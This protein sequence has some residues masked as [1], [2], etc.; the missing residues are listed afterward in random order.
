MLCLQR[1]NLFSPLRSLASPVYCVAACLC[2]WP[3]FP[4]SAQDAAVF[5]VANNGVDNSSCGSV[6]HPCRSI[7]R[8]IA[9]ASDGEL[10]EVGPGIYGDIDGDGDVSSV[11]EEARVLDVLV[12]VDKAVTIYSQAGNAATTIRGPRPPA[13]DLAL[14]VVVSVIGDG[15][16]FG[17]RGGGFTIE[18]FAPS[19]R[20]GSLGIFVDAA[21]ASVIGNITMNNGR[22]GMSLRVDRGN[23]LVQDNVA[24]RN[25]T[26][27]IIITPLPASVGRAQLDGNIA[28]DNRVVGFLTFGLGGHILNNNLATRN[29]AGF[30]FNGGPGV[31]QNNAA[32]ANRGVGI[33]VSSPTGA[34]TL[35]A[36]NSAIGNGVAGFRF[37]G[38][39]F[40]HRVQ[41]N[42]IFGNGDRALG[43]GLTNQSGGVLDAAQNYWGAP[44]GTGPNPADR[45]Y[46]ACE[47][48]GSSTV[49]RPFS[50][51]PFSIGS[52]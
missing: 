50:S 35:F 36:R 33:T 51:V 14:F 15:A 5:H 29:Q 34:S 39:T 27:F 41:E 22:E 37:D 40:S 28:A 2:F 30:A 6:E 19:D 26:G 49:T 18:G 46:G 38:G 31:F 44:T 12:T 43:C 52:D 7:S 42:N 11:G 45:A 47:G 20:P 21:D 48:P 4:L 13:P 24:S 1:P 3:A 17:R 23:V 16:T 25:Q 9:H 8:A 10:I 32:L